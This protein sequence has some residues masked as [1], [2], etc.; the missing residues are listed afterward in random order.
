V[1]RDAGDG[2]H[3]T[4]A[5]LEQALSVEDLTQYRS[6][7]AAYEAANSAFYDGQDR[8]AADNRVHPHQQ[9]VFRVRDDMGNEVTDYRVAFHVVD[10]SIPRGAWADADV[11][12]GL[13]KYR[14]FTREL[15]ED[16]IVDVQPHSVNAS[17]RTFFVNLKSLEELRAKLPP[18]SYI[19]MNVDA[20][21]PTQDL[22]YNTDD[23][24]YLPVDLP[25]AVHQGSEITFF[26]PNTSTLVEMTISRVPSTRVVIFVQ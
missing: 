13:Q 9:F 6:V 25:L 18:G 26:K 4:F 20:T 14:E 2:G 8:L 24:K 10:K 1:P 21:G 15:Q 16:V 22:V 19:A 3:E 11:L 12:A 23:L 17:Y 5:L 7:R